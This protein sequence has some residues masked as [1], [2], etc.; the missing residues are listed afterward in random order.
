[1]DDTGDC[2]VEENASVI[3]VTYGDDCMEWRA[4]ELDVESTSRAIGSR[5]GGGRWAVCVSTDHCNRWR[6][7][8]PHRPFELVEWEGA[9]NC[10]NCW[11]GKLRSRVYNLKEV[12][13]PFSRFSWFRPPRWG[14][15]PKGCRAT[16]KGSRWYRNGRVFEAITKYKFSFSHIYQI[17][18]HVERTHFLSSALIDLSWSGETAKYLTPLNAEEVSF[19]TS[20]KR[21][22]CRQQLLLGHISASHWKCDTWMYGQNCT[23]YSVIT[24]QRTH[25]KIGERV[26]RLLLSKRPSASL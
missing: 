26:M 25:L 7:E 20:Q 18:K 14:I 2:I 21:D 13:R 12:I 23:H 6:S 16:L 24:A 19:Q 22:L 3:V 8:S 1:M 9:N 10:E 17:S 15:R 4:Y 11:S 5:E